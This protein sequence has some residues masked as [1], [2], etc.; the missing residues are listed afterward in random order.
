MFILQ[1]EKNATEAIL[2]G[3]IS[4]GQTVNKP[5]IGLASAG[6][7][8]FCFSGYHCLLPSYLSARKQ[9]KKAILNVYFAKRKKCKN[10]AIRYCWVQYR[11][12]RRSSP[13]LVQRRRAYCTVAGYHCLKLP[14]YL[15]A[16]KQTKNAILNFYF[17]KR[18][19]RINATETIRYCWVQY[20]LV[21]RS[22]PKLV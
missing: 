9:T 19:K 6:L 7:F 10:E 18:K 2:L 13:K 14:S 1:K 21:R 16:R 17:T 3:A 15:S 5:K 4:L 11:L 20:R 8:C 12:V 22:S